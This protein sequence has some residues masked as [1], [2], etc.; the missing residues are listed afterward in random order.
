MARLGHT[1]NNGATGPHIPIR[2]TGVQSV[3][4][5]WVTDNPH[6]FAPQVY[7]KGEWSLAVITEE[8]FLCATSDTPSSSR[9]L[10]NHRFGSLPYQASTLSSG[11][12][13]GQDSKGKCFFNTSFVT[14]TAAWSGSHCYSKT[15]LRLWW[16]PFERKERTE[17]RGD[18][19]LRESV[20]MLKF[21]CVICFFCVQSLVYF[22][23]LGKTIL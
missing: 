12:A 20:R 11:R 16:G 21:D 18:W 14:S 9:P 6:P 2:H 17:F 8:K 23:T 3:V 10:Q 19:R 1:C 22:Y 4:S 15:V 5:R 13:K 7:R